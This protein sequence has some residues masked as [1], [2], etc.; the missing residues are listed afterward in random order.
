VRGHARGQVLAVVGAGSQEAV[1]TLG[2]YD[3][4][5]GAGHGVGAVLCGPGQDNGLGGTAATQGLGRLGGIRAGEYRDAIAAC[6]VRGPE[7]LKGSA[8]GVAAGVFNK[9]NEG[10]HGDEGG[11]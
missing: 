10:G 3:L 5:H 9:N 6:G 11:S 2:S 1:C 4:R 7:G 8:T